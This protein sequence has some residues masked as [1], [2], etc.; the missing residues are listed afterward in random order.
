MD[1]HYYETHRSTV[2]RHPSET[3]ERLMV[4]VLAFA[5]DAHEHLELAKGLST[6]DEPD[7]WRTSLSGGIDLWVALGLP[8]EKVIRQSC[9]KAAEV[10]VYSYG[11]TADTWWGRT[12]GA[13]TRFDNLTVINLA[14]EDTDAL[15]SR[16]MKVQVNIQEGEVKAL[17][18]A[19]TW[20][21]ER[22]YPR[23]SPILTMRTKH[24]PGGGAVSWKDQDVEK[25]LRRHGPGSMARLWFALA[26][27][28]ASRIGDMPAM[29]RACLTEADG[30]PALHWQPAKA[31]SQPV[32]VLMTEMLQTELANHDPD[33]ET[34]LMTEHVT[35]FASSGSLDNRI[36]EWIIQAGIVDARG[37]ANRSQHGIRKGVAE[38]L[39]KHGATEY[40]IMTTLGHSD[41]RTTRQYTKNTE[42]T[43]MGLSASRKR[44]AKGV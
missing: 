15:A 43:K 3:D 37:K 21:E 16:S 27:C 42:R 4:R 38:L 36:R 34:F 7:I 40:E 12:K 24:K 14:V 29:G 30:E 31:G 28:T 9:N 17:R 19:Y 13:T 22:G 44:A 39:A 26:D 5:L 1:R 11:R 35:P 32:T 23:N 20:G 10:V 33:R 6:D 25:F 8:S 2:T 18:A 41:P